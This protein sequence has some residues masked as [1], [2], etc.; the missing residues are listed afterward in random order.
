MLRNIDDIK[1]SLVDRNYYETSE[2]TSSNEYESK[3]NIR[4]VVYHVCDMWQWYMDFY[5]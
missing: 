4:M 5:H 2:K 1:D 3:D